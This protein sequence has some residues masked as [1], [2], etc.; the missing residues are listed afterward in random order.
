MS[1]T[2][3]SSHS[4]NRLLKYHEDECKEQLTSPGLGIDLMDIITN[5]VKVSVE[6]ADLYDDNYLKAKNIE[7]LIDTIKDG[8]RDLTLEEMNTVINNV[9]TRL[10]LSFVERQIDYNNAKA[11]DTGTGHALEVRGKLTG[12]LEIIDVLTDTPG[13]GQLIG[14]PDDD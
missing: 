8:A 4:V 1:E 13:N 6:I 5:M 12:L 11:W 2:L 7:N 3:I 14:Q 10:F 9:G